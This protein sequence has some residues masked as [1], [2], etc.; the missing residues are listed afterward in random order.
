MGS[1]SDPEAESPD[2]PSLSATRRIMAT[3]EYQLCSI[4][5][6]PP[7]HIGVLETT[8]SFGV[9]VDMVSIEDEPQMDG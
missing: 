1:L 4:G 8:E 3:M 2:K 9:S 5:D 6:D 7:V